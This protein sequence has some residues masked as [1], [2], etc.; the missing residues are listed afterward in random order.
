[1]DLAL[2]NLD[3]VSGRPKLHSLF[4]ISMIL[5]VK[6][7]SASPFRAPATKNS[8]LPPRGPVFSSSTS[9]G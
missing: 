5:L 4:A 3:F 1:L 8:R 9:V 6:F 7:L 2:V